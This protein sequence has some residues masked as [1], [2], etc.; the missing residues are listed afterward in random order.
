MEA[1]ETVS[2]PQPPPPIPYKEEVKRKAIHL[3]ALIVPLG[4]ALLGKMWSI[5]LLVPMATLATAADILRV[6]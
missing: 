1:P 6:R 4:M 2:S 5:Y 3:F